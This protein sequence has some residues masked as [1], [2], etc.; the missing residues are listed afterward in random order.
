MQER[1]LNDKSFVL[2]W[3]RKCNEH[4]SWDFQVRRVCDLC[5]NFT[6]LQENKMARLR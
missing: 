4:Y 2:A 5:R 1:F 3:H 6:E